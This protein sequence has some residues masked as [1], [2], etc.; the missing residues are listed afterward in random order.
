MAEERNNNQIIRKDA[1][2]CFVESLNDAFDIGK[3]HFGFATYDVNKPVGQRQTDNVQ[4]YISADEFLELHRK[5][6]SGELRYLLQN[7]KKNGDKT[8]IYQSLGG[9]SA[10]RLAK[11]NHSRSDGMS[12]SRTVQLLC[13]A[14]SDFL[15]VADSGPGETT[16]KGLIVPKFGKTPEN[17]VAISMAFE[18]FAELILTTHI[19]YSAWL[20]A[21]Y[22]QK[23]NS[24]T[25]PKQSRSETLFDDVD[26]PF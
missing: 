4:I 14:K 8:P 16:D 25:K 18:T 5:V 2:N 3:I 17:H 19:H 22:M 10:E 20:S 21:F 7:K 11:Q 24:G 1:K 26:M 15:L 6:V 23:F 12:L 13:G 9:T